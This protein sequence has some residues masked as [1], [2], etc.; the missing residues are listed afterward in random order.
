MTEDQQDQNQDKS[1]KKQSEGASSLSKGVLYGSILETI[2]STPLIGLPHIQKKYDLKAQIIAKCEFFNPLCSSKDRVAL[3][4]FEK[5]EKEG[6]IT[7]GKSIIIVPSAGNMAISLAFIAAAKKYQLYL[8]MPESVPFDR[9]KIVEH[10]GAQVFLTT[11]ARGMKGAIEKAEELFEAHSENSYKFSLFDD[12]AASVIHANTT[13]EE[14]WE[15]SKGNID[16][17]VAGVGTGAT[18]SGIG[19]ALKQKNPEIKIVAVEPEESAV[20]SGGAPT[21]HK[22]EGI[23]V[24]FIPPF[25]KNKIYDLVAKINSEKALSMARELA[26]EEGI[27]CGISSGASCAAAIELAKL[28]ENEGKVIACILASHSE[29]YLSTDLFDIATVSQV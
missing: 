19:K 10:Y 17:F 8:T 1:Q 27:P 22:I 18:I 24:G 28:S 4:L 23:G 16:Y 26:K 7:P 13:A 12:D 9:R 2:G 29:R 11:S 3:A 14:L 5:A 6:K 21:Q 25:L 15:D 20:L